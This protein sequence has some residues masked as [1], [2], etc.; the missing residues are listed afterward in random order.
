MFK[1]MF[2][3]F[4]ITSSAPMAHKV[5]SRDHP[6]PR[7][8]AEIT[9]PAPLVNPNLSPNTSRNTSSDIPI[10]RH[11]IVE[12]DS[13]YYSDESR[14]A[15]AGNDI[16][17]KIDACTRLIDDASKSS[18]DRSMYARNRGHFRYINDDIDESI[19]DY[20]DSI[21][22][23]PNNVLAISDRSYA[24]NYIKKYDLA[25]SDADLAIRLDNKLA[26]AYNSRAF[27]RLAKGMLKETIEDASSAIKIDP[28]YAD[29]F[30][31]RGQAYFRAENYQS[32]LSDAEE[33][34][35]L[36]PSNP[37][38][39]NNLGIVEHYL[40]DQ[41]SA[42]KNYTSAIKLAPSELPFYVNRAQA[43]LDRS[44]PGDVDLAQSDVKYVLNLEPGNVEALLRRAI[45]YHSVGKIK[46]S[47]DDFS[48]YISSNPKSDYAIDRRGVA[49]YD[50]GNCKEAVD[51]FTKSMNIDPNFKQYV[52]NRGRAYKICKNADAAYAD[53]VASDD[54]LLTEVDWN[55]V[56]WM[57][58]RKAE[59]EEEY[60]KA[61]RAFDKAIGHNSKFAISYV[62]AGRAYTESHDYSRALDRL[63]TAVK[64]EPHNF[65]VYEARCWL[66][67]LNNREVDLGRKDC[68]TALEISPNTSIIIGSMALIEFRNGKYAEAKA[69]C[70]ARL[71]VQPNAASAMFIRGLAKLRLGDAAGGKSDIDGAAKMNKKIGEFFASFG[72]RA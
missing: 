22:L 8:K 21:R 68:S 56:G 71:R 5:Q 29:A 66:R 50:L 24:Y 12:V 26:I 2:R 67:A 36:N 49:F 70:D 33:A 43:Y 63:S 18:V 23:N 51:D 28:V 4:Y 62:G 10:N 40:S 52:V 13:T 25:I 35:H 7:S 17:K 45:I 15:G 20:S 27:S 54:S 3:Q 30:N 1:M 42:V 59:D 61:A 16:Q 64:L 57:L 11:D 19:K 72:I 37:Q 38:Y 9:A 65:D 60:L 31:V 39:L 41:D 34:A 47:I 44:K 55:D 48:S 14:C 58:Y 53:F 32:A 6:V 46:E 69:D